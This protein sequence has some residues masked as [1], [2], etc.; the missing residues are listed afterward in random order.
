MKKNVR[1]AI[2]GCGVIAPSHI[3]SY[4]GRAEVIWLCDMVEEKARALAS[5]YAVP[6][7]TTDYRQ[8]L[9]DPEVEAISV[10]TDHAEHA[11]I[12]IEALQAGKHV[13][14]E[15]PLA[16]SSADMDAMLDTHKQFPELVFAGVFQHR[17]EKTNQLLFQLMQEGV[18][19]TVLTTHAQVNCLRTPEYYSTDNWRGTWAGE[20]GSTLIN[21]AIHFIDL[22]AWLMGGATQ[23]CGS[24]TNLT[25]GSLIET[26]DT[27][28]AGLRFANGAL[29][30]LSATS[31]SHLEW[32]HTLSI[33][34]SQGSLE[35]CNDLCTK[36]NFADKDLE[37]DIQA[38]L[39]AATHPE[40]LDVGKDYYGSGHTGQIADFVQAVQEQHSPFVPAKSARHAVDIVL[41]VYRSHRESAWITL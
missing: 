15:K 25:H 31:S 11:R 10:C 9:A 29:G 32:D 3:V 37:Q 2:I 36:I 13:L 14:C 20:G 34:G 21:Q 18:F 16:T 30:T 17:F 39:D 7:I 33:Q 19:G 4:T 5:K 28:V 41:A 22:Q 26:E 23:V 1:V 40:A 38:R 35:L 27:A 12:C 8:V 6:N 24:Y